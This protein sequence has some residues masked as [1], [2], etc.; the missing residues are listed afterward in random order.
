VAFEQGFRTKFR[1]ALQIHLSAFFTAAELPIAFEDGLLEGPQERDVGCVWFDNVRPHRADWNNEEASF[2]VRVFRHFKQDQGGTEP[3]AA[4]EEALEWTFE[5][6][7]D[8]LQ[9]VLNRPLLQ[10]SSG[11][12]LS[13]WYDYFIVQEV[14]L[15]HPGQ[16]VQATLATQARSRTRRG[17]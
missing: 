2:G 13:G 6:L 15:V 14:I 4:Q 8:A 3:R 9:A 5:T 11:I 12:D 16:Y 1:K 10:V 17:G 7:E